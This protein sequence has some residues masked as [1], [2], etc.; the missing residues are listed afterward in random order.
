MDEEINTK[1]NR[2]WIRLFNKKNIKNFEQ[3]IESEPP[4][5]PFPMHNDVNIVLKEFSHNLNQLL[6]KYFPLVRLSR[7]KARKNHLSITKLRK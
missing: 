3:N 5:L 4:L 7:K 2:P 1:K 6:N